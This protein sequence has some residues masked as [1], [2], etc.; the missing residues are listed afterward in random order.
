MSLCTYFID[1]VENAWILTREKLPQGSTFQKAYGVLDR[2]R[3]SRTFFIKI[4]Q[5]S[6]EIAEAEAATTS[7]E[8]GNAGSKKPPKKNGPKKNGQ[9]TARDDNIIGSKPVET[10]DSKRPV[11]TQQQQQQSTTVSEHPTPQRLPTTTSYS[12]GQNK[13]SVSLPTPA[14]IAH[15]L[16]KKTEKP[17][18]REGDKKTEKITV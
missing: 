16:E 10:M 13:T 15:E 5:N 9:T 3:L 4:D 17:S 14:V 18:N 12:T 2:Y 8:H 7:P 1:F 6:C 11:S